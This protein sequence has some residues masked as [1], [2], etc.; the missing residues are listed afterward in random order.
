MNKNNPLISIIIPVYNSSEFILNTLHSLK[1]QSYNHYEIILINDGSTDNSLE[2][3]EEYKRKNNHV[4][5]YNQKNKG[6][7][8]ARNKG[9]ELSS[10]EFVSFLDSDDMYSSYFLEKMLSKQIQK[11]ADVVY[12]GYN[13]VSTSGKLTVM[14]CLFKEGNILDLYFQ[15]NGYFHFSGML[16]R[17]SILLEKHI[18]FEVARTI[19]EDL[20]FTVQLLNN[21]SFYCVKEHLFNYIQRSDSVMSSEWSKNKWLSDIKG[22]EQILLYLSNNYD[23]NDKKEIIQLASEFIFQREISYMIDCIKKWKYKAINDY[24]VESNFIKKEQLFQKGKLN[25]K[26]KK[27]FLIIKRKNYVIWFCYTLYYRFFRFN[28]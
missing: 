25:K 13:R 12:C 22:R 16:I 24:L 1:A 3:L 27:K 11:N 2:I 4:I 10:G 28:W 20:L 8:A 18:Y 14:P 19:S 15:Q 21:C 6:V 7:S 17:K 23:K 9:I 5:L 26:D